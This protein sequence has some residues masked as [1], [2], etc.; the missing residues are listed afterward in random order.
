MI[1]F[2]RNNG[3]AI[4]TPVKDQFRG[5]G[6]ASRAVGYDIPAIRVDGND[7]AAVYAAT[8]EAR[9]IAVTEQRPVRPYLS[10]PSFAVFLTELLELW[11]CTA[12]TPLMFSGDGRGNDV[13]RW[14]SLHLGRL[15]S[16][17]IC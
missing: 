13:P 15:D 9:R 14:T 10:P 12:V 8:V 5:D 11:G 6:I 4:S 16:L 1:F 7:L 2:V 17:Q 3:Y